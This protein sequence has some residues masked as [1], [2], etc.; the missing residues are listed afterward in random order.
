MESKEMNEE[1]AK[2]VLDQD[3]KKRT[4][5]CSEK[6]QELLKGLNC[7]LDPIVILK[8]GRPAEVVINIIAN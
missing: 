1:Q 3:K 8:A 7:E 5:E 2:A 6:L 4:K